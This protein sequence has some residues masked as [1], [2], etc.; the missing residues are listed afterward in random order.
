MGRSGAVLSPIL[1]GRDGH[2]ELADARLAD[3]AAG[4]G[5]TLLIAGEA[6][7]GKTRFLGAVIRA[8]RARGFIDVKGD[9]APQDQ[10]VPGAVLLDLARTNPGVADATC[11]V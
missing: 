2:L 1:V 8:A 5:R 10:D 7:I 11:R 3:G 9:L 4:R 6:G